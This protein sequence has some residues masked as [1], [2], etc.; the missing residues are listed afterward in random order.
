MK[1]ILVTGAGGS[2]T[3][4]FVDSLRIAEEDFY[5]V[6]VDVKPHHIE[7]TD[8]NKR[9]LIP[10]VTDREYLKKLN[11]IIKKEK[12][13]FIHPQPD[14]EVS[15]ISKN[16]KKIS[17]KTFLPSHKSISK[18]QNKIG[19]VN[20][21]RSNKISTGE[22]FL[23]GNEKNLKKTLVDVLRRHKKVWLR[24]IKG[25]GSKAS[26]PVVNYEQAK[27]WIEY[28]K[29]MKG[30]SYEDFMIT[31]FLPGKEF[32][33]QSIWKDGELI[34]SM[35]RQRMEYFYG[36]LT[37]SGQT[38]T[39]S[40]AVTV[41]RKDVNE[42]G[43]MAVKAVDKN[44]SGIFC[45][46]MKENKEDVPCVTEIN[47]GRFFTTSNFFARAGSN[48]PY[49]YIK[50]AFGEKIPKLPT[51]DPIPKDW[52]WVRMADMGFKLVKGGK[53]TSKKI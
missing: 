19:L 26:L 17:A 32:A 40:V 2:A 21:L 37:P 49:Y 14:P 11:K 39:P 35:A 29:K 38:S 45:V 7:L 16:R 9:Y 46:D 47:A 30:V 8:L 52:Y 1:K 20:V 25:A 53:W 10:N 23:V 51:Y 24:A 13:Q 48:M 42:I 36:H 34:T 12:I 31:E 41:H 43:T 27:A 18:C 15:F 28:W 4:N 50:L 33:F 3:H 22:S 6:G 44:A 5:I